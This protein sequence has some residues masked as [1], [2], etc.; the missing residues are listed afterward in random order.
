MPSGAQ[1]N[2]HKKS[3]EEQEANDSTGCRHLK[4]YAEERQPCASAAAAGGS[5]SYALTRAG[6]GTEQQ[7]QCHQQQKSANYAKEA[8][9]K[10]MPMFTV[11]LL[12][13]AC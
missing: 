9:I 2:Q 5:V 10:L 13:L 3:G 12:K 7:Q 4:K 11:L 8:R 1:E 6:R